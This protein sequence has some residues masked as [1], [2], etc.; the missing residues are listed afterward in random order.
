MTGR[1]NGRLCDINGFEMETQMGVSWRWNVPKQNQLRV[2]GCRTGICCTDLNIKASDPR[3]QLE[4]NLKKKTENWFVNVARERLQRNPHNTLCVRVRCKEQTHIKDSV[5]RQRLFFML[6]FGQCLILK[7]EERERKCETWSWKRA[8]KQ[9][10][11]SKAQ[12]ASSLSTSF[13]ASASPTVNLLH[14]GTC[15]GGLCLF[16]PPPQGRLFI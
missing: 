9:K 7:R 6:H 14:R 4:G 5:K 13:C 15:E 16:I 12:Q 11:L 3:L 8:K 2:T 10:P 1:L